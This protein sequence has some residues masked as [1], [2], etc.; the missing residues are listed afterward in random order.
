[1]ALTCISL[2]FN[3]AEHFFMCLLAFCMSSLEKCLFGFSGY[4]LTGLLAGLFLLDCIS[5]LYI[6]EI[7]PLPGIDA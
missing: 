3:D 4:F 5:C 7:K 2:I 6:L 1:M